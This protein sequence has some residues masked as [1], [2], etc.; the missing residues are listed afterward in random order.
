[1]GLLGYLSWAWAKAGSNAALPA[2]CRSSRRFMNDTYG[3]EEDKNLNC[4][5][6]AHRFN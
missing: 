4:A 5:L 1:M 6:I 2:A 3:S